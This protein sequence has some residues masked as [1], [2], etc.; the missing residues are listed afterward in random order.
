MTDLLLFTFL[1][2]IRLNQACDL[3]KVSCMSGPVV[4]YAVERGAA[5]THENK[6]RFIE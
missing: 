2:D 5:D 4:G 1:F 6:F 3:G